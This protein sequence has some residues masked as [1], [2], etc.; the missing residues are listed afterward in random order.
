MK[1]CIYTIKDATH[2]LKC[3]HAVGINGL[4]YNMACLILKDMGYGRVKILVFGDRYWK[5]RDHIKRIRY[6]RKT[7]I[8]PISRGAL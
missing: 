7:R 6:V 8:K 5:G 4:D 3:R 2:Y 1:D